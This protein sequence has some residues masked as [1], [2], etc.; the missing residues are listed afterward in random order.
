L[1]CTPTP[2]QQPN[3]SARFEGLTP[4]ELI[5][6]FRLMHTARRLDDRE[7]TLKRQNRIYFQISGAGH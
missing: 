3:A 7:V 6:A 1:V 2:T 5:R 4:E